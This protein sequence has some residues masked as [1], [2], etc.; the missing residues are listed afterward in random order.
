MVHPGAKV[1]HRHRGR[2]KPNSFCFCDLRARWFICIFLSVIETKESK[3]TNMSGHSKW[4]KVKH[5]KGKIDGA[6]SRVFSRCSKEISV[7]ARTGGGDPGF[8]P[9]LR[10]AIAAARAA[11][12]P[13]DNIERAIKRG[14]GE[15]EGVLYEESIYEGYAPGGVAIIVE[16][17][18]DNRNRAAAE[19]RSIFTK[20]GGS[21]A[22]PGAV[23]YQFRRQGV[24]S[25]SKSQIK[26]DDMMTLA[27]EAGADDMKAEDETYEIFTSVETFDTVVEAIKQ[28]K[29]EPLSAK[30][31]YVPQTLAP[32][33]DEALARR[34][35]GL[36]D[37]LDEQDDVQHVHTNFDIPDAVLEKIS[38]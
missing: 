38:S 20:Q 32:I 9:R 22:A 16:V 34:V 18:T 17:L 8:N 30:R 15:L 6:R 4:S 3:V 25:V 29:I 36:I 10:T 27:L 24:I 26:E 37:T 28:K 14:T 7:T 33:A 21:L 35:L 19:I 23:A 5:F 31:V 11:N 13:V 2:R 12:M 1:N